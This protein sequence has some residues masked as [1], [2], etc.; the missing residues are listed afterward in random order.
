MAGLHGFKRFALERG[1][2]L[3]HSFGFDLR[4][5]LLERGH[6]GGRH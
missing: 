2:L 5:H 4:L 1:A 3:G 6:T